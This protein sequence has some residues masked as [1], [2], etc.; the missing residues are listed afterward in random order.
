[1]KDK[2]V[3]ILNGEHIQTTTGRV[4]INNVLPEAMEFLNKTLGKRELKALL[5]SIFDTA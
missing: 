2:V 4:I 1:V 5:S 3:L